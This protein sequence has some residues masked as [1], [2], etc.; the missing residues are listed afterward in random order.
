MKPYNGEK[1]N[2]KLGLYDEC[3]VMNKP[4]CFNAVM[5]KN[6]GECYES[7]CIHHT[8]YEPICGANEMINDMDK[9]LAI[10]ITFRNLDEEEARGINNWRNYYLSLWDLDQW[11][12]SQVK[13]NN[14]L[15]H[16]TADAYDRVRD[17]LRDYMDGHGCSLEDL[18]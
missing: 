9:F 17:M 10:D 2:Q 16:D 12:R 13:Y 3:F 14:D 11:L 1:L 7:S 5:P 4:Y 18:S 15:S 8:K 6:G